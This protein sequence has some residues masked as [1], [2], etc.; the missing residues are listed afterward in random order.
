[1]CNE[2]DA[3]V[4]N[5]W[6]SNRTTSVDRQHRV[7]NAL[8]TIAQAAVSDMSV[9]TPQA[10]KP[11]KRTVVSLST[12]PSRIDRLEGLMSAIKAQS[13]A[14]DAI[15]IGI[16]PF[17]P[18]MKQVY[19]VPDYLANDPAV[20]IV[21]LPVDFGPLS[22]LAA[23]LYAEDDPETCIIT[24]DDDNLPRPHLFQ[25][26][27]TWAAAFPSAVIG[28]SGW[29]VTCILSK[30]PYVCGEG[31][32]V[33][34]FVR[35]D[36]DVMCHPESLPQ[37]NFHQCLGPVDA[38]M[39][40]PAD[41]VMGVS[42]P[43][44]RR[45]FF[46][47]DFLDVAKT[48]ARRKVKQLLV[49]DEVARRL[50]K[51][52]KLHPASEKDKGDPP[53]PVTAADL[54]TDEIRK[55]ALETLKHPDLADDESSKKLKR[56]PPPDQLFLVDDVYISAYMSKQGV[57]KLI[58]PAGKD[59]VFPIAKVPERTGNWGAAP[60]APSSGDDRRDISAIDALHGQARFDL[61]NYGAVKYFHHLQWW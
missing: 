24:V 46:G 23:A 43:L 41:V 15:L 55:L 8:N 39:V 59:A 47:P 13:Y 52:G 44:Y 32:D 58:V 12:I 21:P 10:A 60:P 34:V 61:A 56:L 38:R 28:E 7:R 18:R 29:N 11:C 42:N 30:I 36:W 54:V 17:A 45:G 27:A 22:K 1:M 5:F 35:Q 20:K 40:R 48:V 33:Y 25:L 50:Q 2:K 49:K 51:E 16:P 6:F 57:P 26:S 37:Y 4:A 3:W 14:P 19:K 53:P 31:Y 9:R